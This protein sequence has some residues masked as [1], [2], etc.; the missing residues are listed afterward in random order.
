VVILAS[1]SRF[2]P[3]EYDGSACIWF[4]GGIPGF[5]EFRQFVLV[6]KPA[7][8]P[9]IFLQSLESANLCFTA[10]PVA[11]ID[12]NYELALTSDDAQIL[13]ER[14]DLVL[15]AMVAATEGGLVTANLL[16]PIVINSRTRTAVQAV[17]ADTRYS[18]HHPLGEATPCS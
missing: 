18:P 5:E 17:R 13:G 15:L 10:V 3:L 9:L 11:A 14:A 4:P 12:A 16:A 1:T 7:L 2:G 6:D 8:A